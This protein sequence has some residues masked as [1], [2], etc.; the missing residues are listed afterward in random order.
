MKRFAAA[1][2]MLLFVAV[3]CAREERTQEDGRA[4]TR[5]EGS[6]SSQIDVTLSEFTVIPTPAVG[7]AGEVTF[8]VT[9]RGALVHEFVVTKSD[10]PPGG[11]PTLEDGSVDEAQID[12]A[13]E[14]EELE[15]DGSGELRLDMGAGS[16]VLFC[17]VVDPP[18]PGQV[19]SHYRRGMRTTFTVP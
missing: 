12:V 19:Q 6:P 14:V 4:T 2:V 15:R 17:N 11:L 13:G 3:A 7:I 9:N 16:Y 5:P 18:A 8:N 1:A 10:L